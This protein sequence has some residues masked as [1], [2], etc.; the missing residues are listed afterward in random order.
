MRKGIKKS[1]KAK[2]EEVNEQRRKG[3]KGFML[4]ESSF[5]FPKFELSSEFKT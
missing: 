4:R 1:K 2:D 3:G 5:E